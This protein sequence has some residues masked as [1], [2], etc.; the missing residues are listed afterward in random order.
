AELEGI[1]RRHSPVLF[2]I[3]CLVAHAD[4]A[5]PAKPAEKPLPGHSM[6]GEAFNEGPR[7]AAVLMPGTGLVQFPI[8]T[9]NEE[10]QKFFTQ[11]VG[12]LHGFWYWEAERS[13]RQVAALDPDCATAYWG[14]GMANINNET[15]AAEFMKEAVKRRDKVGRHEQLWIDAYAAF[16]TDTKKDE[17]ARR[18]ALIGALENLSYEFPDD[19]E[20]KAFLV[21]QLWDNKQHNMPL[22]S[23]TAV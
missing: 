1:M 7:Q 12:Q 14:M 5:P 3:A 4:D 17:N 8:T 19:L 11:G 2:L 23:R 13:F 18:S 16:Y 10:A 20:A 21:F 22:P 15:R 6:N 9:K